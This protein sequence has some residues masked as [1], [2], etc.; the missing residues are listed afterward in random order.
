MTAVRLHFVEILLDADVV[1]GFAAAAGS[2]IERFVRGYL[3]VVCLSL[4]HLVLDFW[5]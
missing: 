4:V 3:P 2:R 5:S 1:R